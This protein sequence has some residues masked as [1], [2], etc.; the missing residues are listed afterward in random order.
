MDLEGETVSLNISPENV[1]DLFETAGRKLGEG[2]HKAWWRAQVKVDHADK[3][4]AKLELFALCNDPSV[5]RH[6]ES[7]AQA[8][9]QRWL[10]EHST[11]ISGLPEE[12]QPSYNE[13]RRLAVEPELVPLD[14]PQAV[15]EKRSDEVRERHLYVDQNLTFPGELESSLE[16][17]VVTD[18][19]AD[20]DAMWWLK[21]PEKKRWSLCVPYRLS[22]E[23]RSLYPD[24]LVVRSTP[25]GLDVDIF[26]PHNIRLVDAPAKAAGVAQYADE[27]WHQFGHILLIIVD[28]DEIRSLDLTDEQTRNTVKA[29]Q[30][31][32]H[33]RQL[34]Q[35][36]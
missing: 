21:N 10:R 2:L 7:A 22:G 16:K 30:T 29:V 35:Q 17:K 32:A 24:F 9:V 3:T 12:G 33:L 25:N 4:Q 20:N 6:V 34:Y 36:S 28:N 23:W 13:I 26:D 5:L 27:H 1:D 11:A 14:Y 19:L 8:T 31:H 18:I 15:E